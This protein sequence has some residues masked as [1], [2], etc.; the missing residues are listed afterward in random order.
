MSASSG[1]KPE[2]PEKTHDTHVG[3]V[4]GGDVREYPQAGLRTHLLY[5][6]STGH[7]ARG[8]ADPSTLATS[9]AL[10]HTHTRVCITATS[11]QHLTPCAGDLPIMTTTVFVLTAASAFIH[12]NANVYS[13]GLIML[14]MRCLLGN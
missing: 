3:G 9:K 4:G 8:L 14:R 6:R 12:V 7:L 10:D 11:L 5:C 13:V 2:L 1:R